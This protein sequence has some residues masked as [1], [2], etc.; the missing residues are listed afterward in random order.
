MYTFYTDPWLQK[1][2]NGFKLIQW[3]LGRPNFWQIL[4]SPFLGFLGICKCGPEEDFV[5]GG[6][7]LM[8]PEQFIK[9]FNSNIFKKI[10]WNTLAPSENDD[11]GPNPLHGH[12]YMPQGTQKRWLVNPPKN[13]VALV[14]IPGANQ[15]HSQGESNHE[16]TIVSWKKNSGFFSLLFFCCS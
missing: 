12:F 9:F 8:E 5:Q 16:K 2:P 14:T 13:R 15:L 4:H 1:N 6:R 3:P 11:S 7:F 10:L